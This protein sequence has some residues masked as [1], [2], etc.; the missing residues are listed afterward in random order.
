MILTVT[1]NPSVDRTLEVGALL[2]GGVV[3][4]EGART[5]PGGKGVNV[6]RVLRRHGEDTTAVLPVGGA[7]G[8]RLSALL[9]DQG[10]SAV[11]VPIAAATRSNITIAESDGVT[12]KLNLPGP[13]LTDA[14]TDTLLG[15]VDAELERGPRW[16]VG[17]GSLPTGVAADFYPRLVR[18]AA[19]HGVPVAIDT[20]GVPLEAAARQGGTALLKPNHEELA[21]LLGRE[22]STIGD[23][24]DAAREVLAWGNQAVLA[25]LGSHGA[26]L[27]TGDG[28]WWA[29]GA[30]VVPRSTVGAGDCALAGY[31]HTDGPPEERLRRAVAWGAAA[32]GLPGTT[33]PGPGDIDGDAVDAVTGPGRDLI[34]KEL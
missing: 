23:V 25:T 31:L 19:R 2:R 24:T 21:E 20:S 11:T 3:R 14:E 1:P 26:L 27:V 17:A 8:G 34:I 33:V 10:V 16:L 6:S 18:L 5:Q 32:V 12:T 22:L 30:A 29:G 13:A 15:A 4:V 7:G 28:T 9:A